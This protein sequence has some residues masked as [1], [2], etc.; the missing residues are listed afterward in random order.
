MKQ[1]TDTDT[2]SSFIRAPLLPADTDT[3]SR[4]IDAVSGMA[5][6]ADREQ[7]A[8]IC[9][10]APHL[11]QHVRGLS[12]EALKDR[13]HHPEA[14]IAQRRQD[15]SSCCQ[16]IATEDQ[17]MTALRQA[18]TQ[19]WL[20]VA[21]GE[22]SGH[23]PISRCYQ[24]LS[25]TAEMMVAQTVRWLTRQMPPPAAEMADD[26]LLTQGGYIVLAL[27]KLGAEEL[28]YSSDIDLICLHDSQLTDGDPSYFIK[29]TRRLV[30][31]LAATTKDG[32]GFRV[33]LRLRPDPGATA[34]SIETGAA[35]S[36]YESQAR[37]WERAA[38]IR[39]RPI[40]GDMAAGQAFL[41]ELR[42]FIWRRSLDYT[43]IEDLRSWL[44]QTPETAS[45]LGF[46][47]KIGAY[48]IRTIELLTHM[49]QLLNGGKY[50]KLRT[51]STPL[52]LT[53]LADI[54]LLEAQKAA[55][56]IQLYDY[57]RQL[58]HRLQYQRDAHTHRLPHGE[59]DFAQF[60]R[61]CGFETADAL[62]T[63]IA[64][65]QSATKEASYHPVLEKLLEHRQ[66]HQNED[67]RNAPEDVKLGWLNNPEARPDGLTELGFAAPE[68]VNHIID[69]WLSGR[70]AATRGGRS[71]QYLIKLLPTLLTEIAKADAPDTA[72]AA[73][74]DIVA[75]QPAGA[76]IFALLDFHPKLVRLLV[77]ILICAPRLAAHIRR[78]PEL[79]DLLIDP[80]FY[81]RLPDPQLLIE[82][83]A[84]V[85][86]QLDQIRHQVRQCQFAL[87]VHQLQAISEPAEIATGFSA[88]ATHAVQH[89]FRL[90][91]ADMRRRHG[92]CPG[93]FAL[94]ALGSF[95]ACSMTAASD[96]DLIAVYDG[97]LEAES[98]GPRALGVSAY[99]VRLTQ[100]I[101]S[102]LTISTGAGALYNVDMRLRPDGG[103]GALATHHARFTSYYQDE[104]LPWE[105]LMLGQARPV[106]GSADFLTTLSA[107][108]TD[109]DS[110]I[111]PQ[112]ASADALLADIQKM[113]LLSHEK[114]QGPWHIK[115]RAG[116]VLDAQ[117]YQQLAQMAETKTCAEDRAK[118]DAAITRIRYLHQWLQ[119][120]LEEMPKDEHLPKRMGS[121]LAGHLK[122]PDQ[123]AVARKRDE[124]CRLIASALDAILA[125]KRP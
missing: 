86:I 89:I 97:A 100:T 24:L 38:F 53:R 112:S 70:I 101:V 93:Q 74:A 124:D 14:Y 67:P 77:D 20:T 29:L 65:L 82:T 108:L 5:A 46:D 17:F 80:Q 113:R 63:H 47:V 15:W 54:G 62:R 2:L 114:C 32:F 103:A 33:D 55:D 107:L 52:A 90:A 13:L 71:Q 58:E 45:Y 92:R 83:D 91:D 1:M 69:S 7:L 61:F 88:L 30:H 122:M 40:A 94:I 118:I 57:W 120:G 104:A 51:A 49:L 64:S 12:P 125:I 106:A 75:G 4:W 84:P 95:G 110:Q 111:K 11:Y 73:F 78:H 10:A 16:D 87:A 42:P 34:I 28:N 117:F 121:L 21:L 60:A 19:I 44:R 98:D 31:I 8:A 41:N 26:A 79:M 25:Q 59:E 6:D 23:L 22:M 3:A 72:F 105:I 27:G 99:M 66:D 36:Y 116:G 96:L 43:V 35:L 68:A 18:R 39:A 48:G 85:E 76:Q 9:Q 119:V 109:I 102:W 123:K 56:L 115:R 50:E 81:S 37:T